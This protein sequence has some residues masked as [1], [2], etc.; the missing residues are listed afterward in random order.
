ME[1]QTK[2]EEKVRKQ[3]LKC[4]VGRLKFFRHSLASGHPNRPVSMS[5]VLLIGS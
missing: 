4:K 2:K 5:K 1:L 3:N